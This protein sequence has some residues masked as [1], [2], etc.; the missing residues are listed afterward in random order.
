M[1]TPLVITRGSSLNI[2]WGKC[3]VWL[4]DQ[5]APTSLCVCVYLTIDYTLGALDI[6]T[7]DACLGVCFYLGHWHVDYDDYLSWLW[8]FFPCFIAIF[9]WDIDMLIM[10]IDHLTL[11]SIVTLIFPCLFWSLHMHTLT[12]VYHLAWHVDSLDYIFSWSSLGMVFLSLFHLIVIAFVWAW[13]IYLVLCLTVWCMSALPPH[14]CMSFVYVGLTSIPLSPALL[15]SVIH[16]IPVL[17]IASVR[18]SMCLLS[19]R[20]GDQE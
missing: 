19:D 15:V 2:N 16:F 9:V 4:V 13:V 8:R 17:T 14:D 11:L 3:G 5:W 1:A 18:S 12:T 10:L 20:A 6:I 7:L